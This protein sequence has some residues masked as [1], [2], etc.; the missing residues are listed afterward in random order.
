MK[1]RSDPT[2]IAVLVC[3][4]YLLSISNRC[5]AASK[6]KAPAIS[7]TFSTVLGRSQIP[8]DNLPAF[9][10]GCHDEHF[11]LINTLDALPTGMA[12][13]LAKGG[14]I[15]DVD[16]DFNS[17][18][19]IRNGSPSRHFAGAAAG[20]D[21]IFAVVQNGGIGLVS[22]YWAFRRHGKIWVG[23]LRW[24][25]SAPV[26]LNGILSVACKEFIP[27]RYIHID[28][29]DLGCSFSMSRLVVIDFESANFKGR[30]EMRPQDRVK[31]LFRKNDI[32]DLHSGSKAS[33][34][35]L[36]EIYSAINAV[37]SA[38][39]TEDN[40]RYELDIFLRATKAGPASAS[41]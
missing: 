2:A 16:Q 11:E 35:Q 23:N 6:P 39:K 4:F 14:H 1:K 21:D 32:Y 27:A 13:L 41:Q 24:Q 9:P 38:M 5:E 19:S 37:R 28:G 20:R 3:S 15:A 30:F 8:S 29:F 7:A 12:N 40:C 25:S 31:W 18:D 17:T 36:T 22:E 34:Q 26:T 10:L 33:P